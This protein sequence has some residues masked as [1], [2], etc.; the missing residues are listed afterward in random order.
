[1]IIWYL[2]DEARQGAPPAAAP[3]PKGTKPSSA[4]RGAKDDL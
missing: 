4:A 3:V 1:M 2:S